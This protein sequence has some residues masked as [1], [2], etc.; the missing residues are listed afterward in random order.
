MK[1]DEERIDKIRSAM[2]QEG[3]D[4]IVVKA[5]E[6]VLYLSGVWPVYG[7][8]YALFH[9]DGEI[10]LVTPGWEE[11][12]SIENGWASEVVTFEPESMVKIVDTYTELSRAFDNMEI[13]AEK[14][15]YDGEFEYLTPTVIGAEIGAMG[16]PSVKVLK[17]QFPDMVD[18][19]SMLRELKLT[20]TSFEVEKIKI[21]NKIGCIGLKAAADAVVEGAKEGD[22]SAEAE[23]AVRRKGIGYKGVRAVRGFAFPVSG[24]KVLNQDRNGYLTSDRALKDGDLVIME[25]NVVADGYWTDL[26]RTWVVGRAN[27]EQEYAHEVIMEARNA[28][29]DVIRSGEKASEPDRLARGILKR[30]GWEKEFYHKTGHGV[31]AVV[32]E[33]PSLHHKSVEIL[34]SS[35]VVTIEPGVY[36]KDFGYLR[37]ED[38]FLV[39]DSGTEMLSNFPTGL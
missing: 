34:Q 17:T 13:K 2:E 6:N 10:S 4:L 33:P 11:T 32:H 23:G 39:T 37:V 36:R 26:T 24:P 8:S 28:A 29:L 19:S 3:F 20:K 5:P 35:M 16:M 7:W 27:R 25:Y 31:G 38:D 21:A 15:G 9:L 12:W 1:R 18:V 22:V 14:V 30:E